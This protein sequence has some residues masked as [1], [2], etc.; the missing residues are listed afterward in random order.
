M[1]MAD[2]QAKESPKGGEYWDKLELESELGQLQRE[3]VHLISKSHQRPLTAWELQRLSSL[4][5]ET[6][7]ILTKIRDFAAGL[8]PK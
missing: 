8:E 3:E 4:V 6:K 1:Q 2:T 7:K 5:E